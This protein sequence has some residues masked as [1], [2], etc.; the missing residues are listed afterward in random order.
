MK[1]RISVLWISLWAAW[2]T[3]AVADVG[4]LP[5]G[6]YALEKT[7][8]YITFSYDHLG[9]SRPHVG[10]EDF[11]VD[12]NLNSA[13]LEA[14]TVAVVIDAASVNSRVDVFNEHLL[15]DNFF[16]VK[17]F[18]TITFNSTKVEETEAGKLAVTGDLTILGKT[19]SVT[20]DATLN[21]AAR[22]PMLRV[23]AIGFSAEAAVERSAFGL[24]RY[25]P[26]VSDEVLIYIE[27]ELLAAE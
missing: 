3:A 14:S 5:S 1:R 18:P 22:H 8:G 27:V 19:R 16:N 25:I 23:P 17:E 15:G 11:T 9:F 13:D 6:E 26:N 2:V 21:K 4:E 12:L 7:H 20:L 24:D 10:F